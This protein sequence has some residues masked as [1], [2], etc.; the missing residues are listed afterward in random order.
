M[1]CKNFEGSEERQA[2]FH[3][4]QNNNMAYIQQAANAAITGAVGSSGYSSPPVSRKR[5]GPEHFFGPTVKDP[6][7]GRMG[8]QANHVRGP[9]PSSSLSPIPGARVGPASLGPSK[10]MY[11][12]LLADIIQP[13][14]L[15]ELCSVLV[16][17]SGQAAKT[18]TDQKN[19]LDKHTEDQTETSLASTQEQLPS[20]KE[21]DVEKAMAN[22]CSSANQTD[23]ISPDNSSSDGADV[24]KGR[25]MSPGTLALMCDEQDTM[26]MTAASPIGPMTHTSAQP[27]YGQ[28]MTEVYAEQERIVLTKFRDFLNRVIT[29]GEINDSQ[30]LLTHECLV[31]PAYRSELE[32][33]KDPI[34]NGTGNGSTEATHRQGTVINGVAKVGNNI[35]TPLVPS[36]LIPENGEIKLKVEK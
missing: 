15:K 27:P 16:L 17:V 21:A 30:L 3:G 18:L 13:Q 24:P 10:F 12:S 20:Q 33:Q 36:S 2:L 26:F 14:H 8:Q 31:R 1:D 25:P 5:K 34:I 19:L 28:G 11:R 23:K 22:D 29:M 4:D 32:S 6:T 7:V 35:S 9:A